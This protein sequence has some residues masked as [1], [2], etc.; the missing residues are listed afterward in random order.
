VI[1]NWNYTAVVDAINNGEGNCWGIK[2]LNI[3]NSS[4]NFIVV[5]HE[6]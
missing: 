3:L 4:Q 6:E 5:N 2:L 1:K